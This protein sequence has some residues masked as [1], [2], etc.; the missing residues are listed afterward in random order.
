[1]TGEVGKWKSQLATSTAAS[2]NSVCNE[3]KGWEEEEEIG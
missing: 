1:M 3:E 2:P